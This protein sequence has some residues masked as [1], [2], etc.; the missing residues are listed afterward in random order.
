MTT[1]TTTRPARRRMSHHAL[2]VEAVTRFGI[3]ARKWRFRCPAC[4]HTQTVND[5]P[6]ERM[7]DVATACFG[8]GR[9]VD[10]MTG[11]QRAALIRV[12]L[13]GGEKTDSFPLADELDDDTPTR[14]PHAAPGVSPAIPGP[15]S[16]ASAESASEAAPVP[17][18]PFL[19]DEPG[20]EA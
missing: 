2:G 4:G 17:S 11:T 9:T 13:P 15:E 18:T 12:T 1:A 10:E 14:A 16:A 20:S 6:P 19:T 3:D 8:C 7:F 5:I